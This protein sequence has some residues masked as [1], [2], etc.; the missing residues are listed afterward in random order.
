M[1][2]ETGKIEFYLELKK[3]IDEKISDLEKKYSQISI[4]RT[5]T[6][7]LGVALLIVG[8][9][10]SKMAAGITGGVFLL[11]FFCLVKEHSSIV[12]ESESEK[13]KSHVVE[14]YIK[15]FSDDW[16]DFESTGKEFLSREDVVALDIDLLGENSLYQ[17]ISTCH[18]DLGKKRLAKLMKLE[19]GKDDVENNLYKSDSIK[20]LISDIDFNVNFEAAGVRLEKKKKKFNLEE[21]ADFCQSETTGV[22]PRWA[23]VCRIILPVTEIGLIIL[24]IAG[25]WGYGIPLL[26]F[27]IVLSFSWLTSSVTGTVIKPFYGL[28]NVLDDYITI[29]DV[30]DKKKFTTEKLIEIK[31]ILGV[32]AGTLRALK[33]LEVISQGYNISFNPLIHQVLSGVVLWDYQLAFFI[34]SWKKKYAA[35]IPFGLEAIGELE[36]LMSFAV[37]GIVRNTCFGDINTKLNNKIKLKAKELYHPLISPDKVVSNNAKL[38]GGI[39]IITGSNM[40]GKTTYLRTL[41]IN[42][43]L[44]YMGAPV[45]G[46]MLEADYMKIF[47]SMRVTDDVANGISTFYAEILRIKA[48]ADYKS[49][50]EPM[51][52]LIDEIFKGTNSAD[53]IVGAKEAITRLAGDNCITIV[54]THDFE[55]CELYDYKGNRA[56]NYHFEEYYENN[57]LKFDYK[58]K[59]ERCKTTNAR[60]I[61]KMAG[62]FTQE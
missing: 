28:N 31:N 17:M 55:L 35:S 5:I 3:S 45:C 9:S 33:K 53:R 18:T 11:A 4:L 58:M 36:E 24:W 38:E 25:V 41:A 59:A 13:S 27:L 43:A 16:R 21:F 19:L 49:K 20:E 15:R 7:L 34:E 54:S 42:L 14:K 10:E 32:E 52:C 50:N 37:L 57:E 6:F 39:T 46:E 61:L 12:K 51:L 1:K 48:M 29:M 60:E 26:G 62:F 30:V 40:S 23:K 47:T 22:L 56:S 2:E 44:A 8:V